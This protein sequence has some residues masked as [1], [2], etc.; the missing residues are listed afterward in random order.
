MKLRT[1]LSIILICS[2]T[3]I[4]VAQR[5][6]DMQSAC[7]YCDRAMLHRVEGIWEY[8]ADNTRV[9]VRRAP[10]SETRYDI[11]AIET[12]DCRMEPGDVVGYLMQ[13]ASPTKFEFGMYRDK[14]NGILSELG[15]GAATLTDSDN[16]ITV[17]SR[18]FKISLAS[19]WFLPQ[20]WRA[21][22]IKIDD[23]ASKLP[24]GMVRIYPQTSRPQ[25]DY[26]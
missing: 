2:A 24:S 20:F 18:K 9:L 26:L 22:R 10:G 16:T 23:P 25:P 14:K 5:I 4:G 11:I 12:P 3:A 8:P 6:I 1:V 15:K 17:E 13:T 7:E 19:R 21:L